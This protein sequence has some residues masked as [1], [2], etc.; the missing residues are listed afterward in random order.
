MSAALRTV[1]GVDHAFAV[2]LM[3]SCCMQRERILKVTVMHS[4]CV[5]T[6]DFV[7]PCPGIP[8]TYYQTGAGRQSIIA[9][10]DDGGFKFEIQAFGGDV[11]VVSGVKERVGFGNDCFLRRNLN[12]WAVVHH[13]EEFVDDQLICLVLL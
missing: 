9:C 6:G 13:L 1:C 11:G 12:Y 3:L 5:L 4:V 2:G 10:M 7:T 8:S